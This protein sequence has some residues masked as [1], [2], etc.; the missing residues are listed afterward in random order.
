MFC[1]SPDGFCSFPEKATICAVSNIQVLI[2]KDTAR[3]TAGGLYLG[4]KA[5]SLN[6]YCSPAV[7]AM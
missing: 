3:S 2:F 6:V 1:F 7:L 5:A 4:L